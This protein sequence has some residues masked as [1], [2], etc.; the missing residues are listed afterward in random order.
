MKIFVT[1]IA[2]HLIMV[3]L[4][5]NPSSIIRFPSITWEESSSRSL[6]S[7]MKGRISTITGYPFYQDRNCK[8]FDIYFLALFLIIFE[9]FKLNL[10]HQCFINVI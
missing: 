10:I 3:G 4:E 2:P 8:F 9:Y 1:D 7:Q 6:H 5:I